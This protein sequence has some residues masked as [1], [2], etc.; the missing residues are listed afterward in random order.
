MSTE[1]YNEML[2]QHR[3]GIPLQSEEYDKEI[4]R[5]I[6]AGKR[7]VRK[8]N[9]SR[10]KMKTVVRGKTANPTTKSSKTVTVKVEGPDP[11][12][13]E[14]EISQVETPNPATEEFESRTLKVENDCVDIEIS[15]CWNPNSDDTRND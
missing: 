10:E 3:Q 13:E 1:T 15:E 5:G 8:W 2:S 14:S 6:R 4:Q 9:K 11:T 12:S 7:I